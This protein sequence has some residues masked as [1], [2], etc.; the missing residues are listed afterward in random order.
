MRPEE[1]RRARMFRR[2]QYALTTAGRDAAAELDEWLRVGRDRVEGWARNESQRALAYA[3]GAGAAILLMRE[4]YPE[5]DQI[6]K[7]IV[8]GAEPGVFDFGAFW[9]ADAGDAG[10]FDAFD[11]FDGIDAGVDAGAG[12]GGDGGGGNGGG[13]DGGGGG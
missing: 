9:G 11:S 4:L 3:G 13:G 5:F 2:R 8:T 6:G 12:W 1:V 10:A 7:R